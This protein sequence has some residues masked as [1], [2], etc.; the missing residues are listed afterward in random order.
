MYISA[1]DL[2]MEALSVPIVTRPWKLLLSGLRE[3]DEDGKMLEFIN[4]PLR[5][6][7]SKQ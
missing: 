5:N 3:I 1:L 6:K 4:G 2:T 7:Q